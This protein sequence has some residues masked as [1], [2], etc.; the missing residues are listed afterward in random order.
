MSIN[1]EGR[2]ASTAPMQNG[3][4][5]LCALGTLLL[6]W[7]LLKYSAYGIDFTDESFYLIWISNPFIYP[8]SVSQ[9]GFIYHPLYSLFGGDIAAL[10]QANILITYALAWVLT[11]HLLVLLAPDSKENRTTLF[12]VSAGL[13]TSALIIFGNWLPTP[14]YNGLA[15]QALL[16]S[17]IGLVL[18][19]KTPHPK[20]IIGWVLVGIGGWLAFMAKPTTAL[21]LAIGALIYLLLARKFSIRLLALAIVTAVA[22]LLASALL[23]DGSLMRFV[24]RHQL[25]LELGKHLGSGHTF[26]HIWRIDDFVLDKRIKL[27]ILLV[28]GILLIAFWG[29]QAKHKKT[30][31]IGLAASVAFFVLT[32]AL[33]LG[34]INRHAGFAGFQ[35]MLVFGLFYAAVGAGLVFGR[36]KAISTITQAQWAAAG[37]LMLMPY[38]YAFG[39]G[40]NYWHQASYSPIFWLLASLVLLLPLIRAQSSWV[41]ALPLVLA[42]QAVTATLLQTGLELPYRQPEPLRLNTATVPFGPQQS[43]LVL[44]DGYAHYI[45]SAVASAKQAELTP[46]TPMIDLSGQSPGILFALGAQSI[47]Q[48][49]TLGGYP[50][51]MAFVQAGLAHTSC[52]KIANAW[53]LLEPDGPRKIPTEFMP[54]LGAHFPDDYEQVGA[55]QTAAGAGGYAEI[56][57]QTLF[58]PVKP[59]KTVETCQL[60]REKA[61]H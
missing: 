20:S 6:I 31:I 55:W 59:Q 47:G 7:W 61:T 54:A 13:A 42:T 29:L 35:G 40:N 8:A 50:G 34:Q 9:F 1:Q 45:E 39:T 17:A 36:R 58:K 5:A 32:A 52:E 33:T 19:E 46:N 15:F 4:T 37:L 41:L 12:V 18:S 22:L 25:G 51:S 23:I 27:A 43:R 16:I 38:M 10:R 44:S 60:Q 26:G 3:L 49:W 11:H 30:Y 53:I 56:R 21:A 48:V 57:T 28:A 24:E 14:G 2:S